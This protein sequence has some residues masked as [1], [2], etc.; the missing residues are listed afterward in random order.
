M[1]YAHKNG[2][3]GLVINGYVRDQKF[4]RYRCWTS[5]YWN[6]SKKEL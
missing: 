6:M 5:S 3:A 1:G 4:K 2:W